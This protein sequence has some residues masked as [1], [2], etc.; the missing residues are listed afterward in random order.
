VKLGID[1]NSKFEQFL[2]SFDG[3]SRP[4]PPGNDPGADRERIVADAE[5]EK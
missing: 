5:R 1:L 3:E 2:R 4:S